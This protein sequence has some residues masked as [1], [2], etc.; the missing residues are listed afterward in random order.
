MLVIS[1]QLSDVGDTVI[2]LT[3]IL[4]A[5]GVLE[6][7]DE[8]SVFMVPLVS[9]NTPVIYPNTL[10]RQ[11]T[12]NDERSQ[13][14]RKLRRTSSSLLEVKREA[15][16][17][18]GRTPL[19]DATPSQELTALRV[20]A[21]DLIQGLLNNS[22]SKHQEQVKSMQNR[23]NQLERERSVKVELSQRAPKRECLSQDRPVKSEFVKKEEPL[24]QSFR[25][26]KREN[27]PIRL[28]FPSGQAFDLTND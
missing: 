14:A 15:P 12:A 8:Q 11:Q 28:P 20:S 9:V 7:P 16:G 1:D 10:K 2:C 19:S 22:N 5:N 24:T 25:P 17:T 21:C 26:V 13:R 6:T 23:L 18:S 3:E 27:S 4:L